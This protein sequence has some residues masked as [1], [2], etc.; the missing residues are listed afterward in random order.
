MKTTV[1]DIVKFYE[2]YPH[3][4]GMIK[5]R[6]RF[7]YKTI[8][9]AAMTAPK[10]EVCKISTECGKTIKTSPD[11]LM[12]SNDCSWVKTKDLTIGKFLFTEEGPTKIKSIKTSKT[13]EDLYDLQVAEVKEYFA[14]GLVS[15]NSTFMD[16]ITFALF[17]KPFRNIKLGQLVNSIN[18]KHCEVTLLFN[19]SG[20]QYKVIRGSVSYTH[21]TLPT[22]RIV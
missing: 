9:G 19:V 2:L 6:T 10:S 8:E 4:V 16:A 20:K 12:L 22:K 21:L 13:K 17:G 7:G 1:G 5:V 14:N 18:G 3:L 15:H 11:H